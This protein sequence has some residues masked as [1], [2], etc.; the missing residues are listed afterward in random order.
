MSKFINKHIGGDLGDN[1][2][3]FENQ[4]NLIGDKRTEKEEKNEKINRVEVINNEIVDDKVNISNPMIKPKDYD[5][6]NKRDKYYEYVERKNI[7]KDEMIRRQ[8]VN[9]YNI[10][11]GRRQKES[12]III[13]KYIRLES[14]PIVLSDNSN[15]MRI[16]VNNKNNNLN[17]KVGDSITLDGLSYYSN[18]YSSISFFFKNNTRQVI[19][20]LQPNFDIIS[21]FS[22]VLINIKNVSN[23]N[24]NYYKNVPLTLIN[25]LHKIYIIELNNNEKKIGFDLPI[26]FYTNNETDQTLISSCVIEFL[27]I[28]NYPINKINANLPYSIYNQ[29]EYHT[30]EEVNEN[31]IEIKLFDSISIN[32]KINI[33][34]YWLNNNFYTGGENIQIGKIK[35]IIRGF[36]NPSNYNYLLNKRLNNVVCI[37]IISSEIPNTLKNIYMTINKSNNKFYWE[38]SNDEY[39][40]YE[41]TI[42]DGNYNIETLKNTM[43]N[44]IS[45][46]RRNIIVTNT[47]SSIQPYNNMIIDFNTTTNTTS[48]LSYNI[49][50]L[51]KSLDKLEEMSNSYLITIKHPQHNLNIN[52]PIIIS[53]SLDYKIISKDDI[54]GNHNIYKII[55][56]D[57]Y[58]IK[59][60][61]INIIIEDI[62]I[63]QN[64]GNKITIR[65][66]NS[67]RILFDKGDTCGSVIGFRNV[68]SSIS[69]TEYA[70]SG[71]N[72][73]ITNKQN[74]IYESGNMVM[75]NNSINMNNINYILL[76]S[77]KLN[78]NSYPNG[79]DYFYKFQINNNNILFNSFVDTPLYFNP[80]LS[81]IDNFNFSFVDNNNNLVDFMNLDHS[82]TIE[83]INIDNFPENS[84]LY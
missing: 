27:N 7:E 29:I 33:S 17:L 77:D 83:I 13:E 75:N 44:L 24:L 37:K 21:S 66:P 18:K 56:S 3:D 25:L 16:R 41:I 65:T 79:F 39:T 64:G 46:V 4:I 61:N 70:N 8:N 48:I 32:D 55:S 11:S 2:D 82:L 62:N 5:K 38:N 20:D 59:L 84:N 31:F 23:N 9:Y 30:I 10:D 52:D 19:I 42:P 81:Y 78:I 80:P 22:D 12:N 58:Q 50:N 51:P 60:E 74:Y 49:Y 57:Y 36:P 28:G 45:K 67:F 14:N 71:N 40:T 68:G 15:I 54:N 63:I 53:N 35:D 72:Y 34:G 1:I 69:V 43:E 76:K 47:S 26:T 73:T 6:V